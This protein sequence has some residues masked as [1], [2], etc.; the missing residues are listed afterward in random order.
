MV[1]LSQLMLKRRIRECHQSDLGKRKT[2]SLPFF[3]NWESTVVVWPTCWTYI[4]DKKEQ[5]TRLFCSYSFLLFH[6]VF[7]GRLMLSSIEPYHRFPPAQEYGEC[8]YGEWYKK[9]RS[10]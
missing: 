1:I 7:G 5:E 8:E 9:D 2:N 10:F 4:R 6:F 3:Y